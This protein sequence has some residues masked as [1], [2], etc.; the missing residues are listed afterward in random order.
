MDRK[1]TANESLSVLNKV[2]DNYYNEGCNEV[3]LIGDNQLPV[4][5]WATMWWADKKVEEQLS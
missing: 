5:C 3:I 1:K 4:K 2:V